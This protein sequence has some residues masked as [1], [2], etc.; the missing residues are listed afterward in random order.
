MEILR[1]GGASSAGHICVGACG[2]AGGVGGISQR[3][4]CSSCVLAVDVLGAIAALQNK[5][6]ITF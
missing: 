6:S 4:P 2:A 1:G 3:L 5:R